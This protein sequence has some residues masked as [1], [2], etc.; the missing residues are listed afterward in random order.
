M[1]LSS[2]GQRGDAARC[3]E[4]GIKAYLL[5]PVKRSELLQAILTTLAVS[6]P[7]LASDRLV[8]RHTLLEDQAVLRVLLAEDNVVN[9]HLAIRLV[10]KA[11][12]HVTL[13]RDGRAAVDM[14][15]AGESAEPF[16]LILMDVQMPE[17]DGLQATGMIRLE[18]RKTGRHIW[19]VAMTAHAMQG[20]R[21]RCLAAG[22]DGY[23]SKP[24]AYKDLL[25]LL[26]EQSRK[27][28]VT[29]RGPNGTP[30]APYSSQSQPL[31]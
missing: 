24:I 10:E 14:W 2:G 17:L 1:M 26:R 25:E 20:D 23:L 30:A 9:Q 27:L 6:S 11:G 29:P 16:D 18:E 13:A 19:I 15:A 3:R 4:I 28:R 7:E 31:V 5:K 22:M 21:E 8:T 12:H